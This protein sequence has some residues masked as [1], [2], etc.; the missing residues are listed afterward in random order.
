VLLWESKYGTGLPLPRAATFPTE[1]DMIRHTN[2][3]EVI[4]FM[5][6]SGRRLQSYEA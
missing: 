1:R 4:A 3:E 5:V 2:E 6:I